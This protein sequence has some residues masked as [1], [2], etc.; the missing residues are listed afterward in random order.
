MLGGWETGNRG[1]SPQRTIQ[2]KQI[3]FKPVIPTWFHISLP[4]LCFKYVLYLFNAMRWKNKTNYDL[5]IRTYF[6][7]TWVCVCGWGV[8]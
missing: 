7:C 8:V 3:I 1:C 5:Q 6:L 2:L 4:V